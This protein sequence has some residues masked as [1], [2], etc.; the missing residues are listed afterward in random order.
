MT[1]DMGAGS[2]QRASISAEPIQHHDRLHPLGQRP[3]PGK[4][5]HPLLRGEDQYRA[6]LRLMPHRRPPFVIV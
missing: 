6:G 4:A 1:H 3:D 2:L 5:R